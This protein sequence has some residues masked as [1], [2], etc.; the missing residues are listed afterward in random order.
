MRA[1]LIL[2]SSQLMRFTFMCCLCEDRSNLE[3]APLTE[4]M[5]EAREL[6]EMDRYDQAKDELNE[7]IKQLNEER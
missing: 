6:N 3:I 7:S 2:P 4:I 1:R 5:N